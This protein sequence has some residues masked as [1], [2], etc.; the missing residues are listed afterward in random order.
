MS[1]NATSTQ[2][3]RQVLHCQHVQCKAMFM[4]MSRNQP[5]SETQLAQSTSTS[6]SW[7]ISGDWLMESFL[8]LGIPTR[9]SL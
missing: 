6:S 2:V 7:T 8:Q 3:D 1:E 5:S 4:C 9:E